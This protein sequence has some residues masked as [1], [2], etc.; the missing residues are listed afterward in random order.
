MNRTGKRGE[1]DVGRNGI[2][3]KRK[4]SEVVSKVEKMENVAEIWINQPCARKGRDSQISR[5]REIAIRLK[6]Q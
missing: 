6:F 4:I 3:I 2:E 5:R 1:G